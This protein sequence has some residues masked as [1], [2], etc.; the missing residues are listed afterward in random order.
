MDDYKDPIL[1]P[2]PD[3]PE[4][5]V[6]DDPTA[7]VPPAGFFGR[8]A[9]PP[10]AP[11]NEVFSPAL[12]VHATEAAATPKK[13]GGVLYFLKVVLCLLLIVLLI[14][15]TLFI[16]TAG[17]AISQFFNVPSVTTNAPADTFSV[18]Y[19]VGTIQNTGSSSG[20][21]Q[22]QATVDYINT[23]A[24]NEGDKGILLYMDTGGGTMYE[25]DE[26]YRALANYTATTGR[27]VWA[28]MASTCASGGY[29]ICMAAD[30]LV[31]NYNT[32][33]GSIGVYIALT[34]TSGLY[35]KLGVR[36]VLVRSGENKGIGVT[37]TEI[38]PENEAVYQS[39]VDESYE[40]FLGL[41]AK[42]RNMDIA[43]ARPL[44]DGR[45]YTANQA[46]ENGLVDELSDW[47]TTLE[48]FKT[49]TGVSPFYTH[50]SQATG[51][52]SLFGEVADALPRGENETLYRMA[53]ELEE[54]PYG[55]P[56]VYADGLTW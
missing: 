1:P 39:M 19:V 51:F 48:D 10:V 31:A 11:Y 6:Q 33:T 47:D 28:Y 42:G 30:K 3:L 5:P 15:T 18:V 55:V 12:P 52:S 36:T 26:V 13:S 29:Y 38:T 20:T 23:L 17:G 50:F 43:T 16:S 56:M 4:T 27:P 24:K 9:P 25:S 35:D 44:A 8:Y 54:L 7:T 2:Q 40:T 21:Y 34:D 22:H 45:P 14:F 53:Q 49:L 41:V 46:L 32:T 37:G